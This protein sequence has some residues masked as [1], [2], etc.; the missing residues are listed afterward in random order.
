MDRDGSNG[1]DGGGDGGGGGGDGDDMSDC[2][3]IVLGPLDLDGGKAGIDDKRARCSAGHGP[4][5]RTGFGI[6]RYGCANPATLSKGVDEFMR[7]WLAGTHAA[8]ADAAGGAGSA[9]AG[10]GAPAN[11]NAAGTG[12]V[13]IRAN[14]GARGASRARSPAAPAAAACRLQ[15]FDPARAA[16][17]AAAAPP[18]APNPGAHSPR[19]RRHPRMRIEALHKR[20]RQG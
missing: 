6:G 14:G 4:A 9:G 3:C 15:L 7:G 8:A 10:A 20:R 19:P 1:G 16:R 13:G 18:Q 5:Y 11:A 12:F 2:D 17:D